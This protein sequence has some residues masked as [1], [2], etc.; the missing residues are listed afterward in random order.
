MGVRFKAIR[1]ADLR[2]RPPRAWLVDGLIPA[3]ILAVLFSESGKGK[4]FTALGLACGVPYGWAW[5][6]T[7]PTRGPTLYLAGEGAGG[8]KSRTDAWEAVNGRPVP[9]DAVLIHDAPDIGHP[10]HQAEVVRAFREVVPDADPALVVVDTLDRCFGEGDEN[11]AQDMRRFVRGC[12]ALRETLGGPAVLVLHH[13][14]HGQSSSGEPRERGSSGLRAAVDRSIRLD[15]PKRPNL[16]PGDR[17][18]LTFV[19]VK[20]GRIPPPVSL[21]VAEAD[22]PGGTSLTVVPADDPAAKLAR[23]TPDRREALAKVADTLGVEPS[24][25]VDVER[26]SGLTGGSVDGF[27]IAALA[28]GLMVDNGETGHGR[29]LAV[30]PDAIAALSSAENAPESS[31]SPE[32]DRA[33]S[34]VLPDTVVSAGDS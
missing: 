28:A 34:P 12:D 18:A 14:G 33:G 13:V 20:D 11:R 17:L 27:V 2:D 5:G 1:F 10:E 24:R 30:T 16:M 7:V 6:R 8:L 32:P 22:V 21:T 25:R 9:P 31:G 29:R 19:K 15:G 26:A 4:T 23:L 3:G